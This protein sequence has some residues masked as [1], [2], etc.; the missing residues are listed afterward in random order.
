[1][2]I[3]TRVR[4]IYIISIALSLGFITGAGIRMLTSSKRQQTTTIEEQF[5]FLELPDS[6]NEVR[7]ELKK[8]KEKESSFIDWNI[9]SRSPVYY[10]ISNIGKE[11][12]YPK[13]IINDKNWSNI[14]DLVKS[15][16]NEQMTDK[17][18][19]IS[20][21]QFVVENR[22]RDFPSSEYSEEYEPIKY[23]NI[24]GY[25]YCDDS[26]DAV[27]IMSKVAGLETRVVQIEG[28]HS[29]AE[30]FYEGGWHMFD[31]DGEVYYEKPDG[32]IANVDEI[33]KDNSI[34][35]SRSSLIY[36][37][38]EVLKHYS[39][40][41]DVSVFDNVAELLKNVKEIKYT[42]RPGE[43]IRFY[44]DYKGKYFQNIFN[45]FLTN[46]ERTEAPHTYTNGFLVT[47]NIDAVM[48]RG[49]ISI[50]L[51]YP[52][53][54]SYIKSKTL[55]QTETALFFSK[56]KI[57]WERIAYQCKDDIVDLSVLLPTR[58]G[59]PIY[60]Y[61]L[62]INQGVEKNFSILTQFQIA[63]LSL[64]KFQLGPNKISIDKESKDSVEIVLGF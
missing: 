34:L 56:N 3:I 2:L 30:I 19:A 61:Y 38:E 14:K 45:P 24:W 16:I 41:N 63:P 33:L 29:L 40:K 39:I 23:F 51:P 62:S 57:D 58:S 20:I 48:D 46:P 54:G 59:K 17:Q 28:F 18:K 12:I 5:E 11:I 60:N 7:L 6:Q 53:L 27:A 4:F 37:K 49:I 42:L 10:Q 64:P 15:I 21:W 55:C 50:K 13:I 32:I 47:K 22:V 31:A 26:A 8:E 52:I 44:F 36:P 35:K 43:E 25:G 1:M 9:P